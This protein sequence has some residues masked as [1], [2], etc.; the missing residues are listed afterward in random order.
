LVLSAYP[1]ARGFGL[2]F[3]EEMLRR[4]R[5]RFDGDDRVELRAHNMDES[6]PADLSGFDAVVSSFAI[7]HLAPVRQRALYAEVFE[8]LHPGGIFVNVEHVASRSDELHV[9]FL[10]SVGRAPEDDDPSNQLVT[11]ETQLDW[12]D[13]IGYEHADCTWKWRELAVL[14]AWKPPVS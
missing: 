9:Q 11:V 10:A 2:D 12:L 6:L 4:A 13:G 7:H 3:Q 8:R 5:E 1:E 14:A